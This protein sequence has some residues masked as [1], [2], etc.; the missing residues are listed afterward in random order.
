LAKKWLSNAAQA[1]GF[2]L[3][4]QYSLPNFFFRLKMAYSLQSAKAIR[5]ARM[6]QQNTF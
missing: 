1:S 2:V 6:N 5:L 3:A 4:A